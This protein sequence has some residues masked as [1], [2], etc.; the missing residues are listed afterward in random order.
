MANLGNAHRG[1]EH[2]ECL[3]PAPEAYLLLDRH[4]VAVSRIAFE[5]LQNG[6]KEPV[7]RFPQRR[8]AVGQLLERRV[9]VVDAIQNAAQMPPKLPPK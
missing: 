9:R 5:G 2:P 3:P 7:V 6:T 4:I 8:R 1:I